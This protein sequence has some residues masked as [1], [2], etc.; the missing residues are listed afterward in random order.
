MTAAYYSFIIISLPAAKSLAM[1][2]CGF[3][4]EREREGE[5]ESLYSS[6]LIDPIEMV[7][8]R[9]KLTI[10]YVIILYSS[11]AATENEDSSRE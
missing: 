9:H 7:E 6:T 1:C 10:T 8:K 4:E 5:R 3:E 2:Y 11:D